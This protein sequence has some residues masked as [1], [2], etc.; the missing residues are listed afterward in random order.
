ML[1]NIEKT[2][3]DNFAFSTWAMGYQAAGG[4]R[5]YESS[6]SK[7]LANTEILAKQFTDCLTNH[8]AQSDALWAMV[9]NLTA[10]ASVQ[11]KDDFDKIKNQIMTLGKT[12][13]VTE[14]LK[15]G[16]IRTAQ[17]N[18][19]PAWALAK[20]QLAAAI[21]PDVSLYHEISPVVEA[22]IE[23]ARLKEN[24]AAEYVLA[25]LDNTLALENAKEFVQELSAKPTLAKLC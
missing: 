6:R 25:V 21:L 17:S 23:G 11:N 10:A 3:E 5:A 18:D 14:A 8:T 2:P 15:Q 12:S 9:M 19:Y 1:L 20:I 4:K 22:S 13:S 7:M 24:N 16:L